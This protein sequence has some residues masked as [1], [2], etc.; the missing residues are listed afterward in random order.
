MSVVVLGIDGGASAAWQVRQRKGIHGKI[1]FP[2]KSVGN[3]GDRQ[4]PMQAN[5]QQ[6]AL[7]SLKKLLCSV[8]L[9]L[10]RPSLS[11]ASLLVLLKHAWLLAVRAA[12]QRVSLIG[13][14]PVSIF[15]L[16]VN[17]AE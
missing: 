14:V 2:R 12:Q 5:S 10:Y 4:T 16:A 8:A 11:P 9:H 1:R 3:I 15:G 17:A 6:A 13:D 7:S